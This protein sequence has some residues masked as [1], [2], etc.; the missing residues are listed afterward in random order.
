MVAVA[1][2]E[3]RSGAFITTLL[4]LCGP[5]LEPAVGI[6][7]QL[8]FCWCDIWRLYP[9]HRYRWSHCWPRIYAR[10]RGLSLAGRW[11]TVKGGLSTWIA[12]LMDMGWDP[13]E[14]TQWTDDLG[15]TWVITEGQMDLAAV[16]RGIAASVNRSLWAQAAKGHLGAGLERPPHIVPLQAR[17]KFVQRRGLVAEAG[18][19]QTAAIGGFGQRQG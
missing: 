7:Q 16:L 14:A 12:T 2:P 6:R 13:K 4:A 8:L 15:A 1:L 10:L 3:Y 5:N 9:Q 19:L 17:L 18:A 11:R